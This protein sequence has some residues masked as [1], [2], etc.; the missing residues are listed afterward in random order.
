MQ[1]FN[2]WTDLKHGSSI[3]STSSRGPTIFALS[4]R[5]FTGGLCRRLYWSLPS[6]S[7]E[8]GNVEDLLLKWVR[9]LPPLTNGNREY[10]LFFFLLQYT[11]YALW[12]TGSTLTVEEVQEDA[13][14]TL[15][16]PIPAKTTPHPPV[17]L[18]DPE[19]RQPSAPPPTDFCARANCI[20]MPMPAKKL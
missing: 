13:C 11:E 14:S 18:A 19:P 10:Q 5:M 12:M 1:M 2:N 6:G 7:L 9:W 20:L 3:S 17:D 8:W 16:V 4:R 15:P